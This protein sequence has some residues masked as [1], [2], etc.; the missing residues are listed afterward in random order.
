MRSGD[1]RPVGYSA[2]VAEPITADDAAI[3]AALAA[4]VV[5]PLVPALA[6]ATG[7]MAMLRRHLRPDPDR[8]LEPE[9]GLTPAELDEARDLCFDA[10]V[11]LRDSGS[12]EPARPDESRLR[13]LMAFLV[14][15]QNVARSY[16]LLREELALAGDDLRAPGWRKDEV[17]PDTDFS[18]AIVGAGMSGILAAHRLRQAGVP[19]VVF[20][21]NEDVGGTWFENTYPGCRVDVPNHLYSYSFAQEA[22]PH[23][24]SDQASLLGYFRRC[25]D[26]FGIRPHIRFGTEVLSA[27]YH[28]DGCTWRVCTSSRDGGIEE[29]EVQAVVSAVGQLNRPKLPEITGLG[30][31]EG[32]A[33]HSAR[34]DHDVD[35]RGK[36]VAVIG[37]G[38]SAAQFIPEIAGE[39]SELLVFQRTANWLVPTPD[40]HDEVAGGLRWLL[41]HV[42]SYAE[43]Y[44]LWLFWRTHEGLLPA[45]VVD[46]G[47]E[48]KDRSVSEKND[49]IRQ[50]L[51][52]YLG[53]QFGGDPELVERVVPDYPPIAKR[54]LRDNG[55]WARTLRS[56]HVHLVTDPIAEITGDGVVTRD[57]RLHE[58]DV[59]IYGTGFEASHFLSPMRITGRGGV[60]LHERWKGDARAYLGIT[61][62]RFPN[63][64]CLYGPNT[65]IVINGS[66]IYFSEC[67]VRYVVESVRL[68]LEGGYDAIDCRP[69]VHDAFN[70]RIDEGNRRMAWGVSSVSSWYKNELGRVAQNWPFTLADYWVET[71]HVR[72]EDYE[73]LSR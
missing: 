3:R 43:W 53:I 50:L 27:E 49:L 57:G 61:V 4:A 56:D 15:E 2:A 52:A 70:E 64:F 7:D 47:W 66:I 45:A 39:V 41:D 28:E 14:G 71:R 33:F 5:A 36:R 37:T 16:D 26:A 6:Q 69:D 65:N 46:P 59:L 60:D 22:W 24:F 11:R 30:R 55:I 73:L 8:A 13:E 12:Q 58:A 51:T 38:A 21:K 29:I 48:P 62:P 20:E 40:Y 44:R 54:I 68:L 32:P 35:L 10:I 23:H 18:V 34:W 19:F 17:A 31:F 42:P 63:L 25:A 67:E 72:L 1:G 9:G